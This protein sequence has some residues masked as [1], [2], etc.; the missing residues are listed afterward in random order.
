MAR[1][2]FA[3]DARVSFEVDARCL[4]EAKERWREFC[5]DLEA[6]NRLTGRGGGTFYVSLVGGEGPDILGEDGEYLGDS[7]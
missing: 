1:F 4:D 2:Q 5:C 3:C 6:N 7:E